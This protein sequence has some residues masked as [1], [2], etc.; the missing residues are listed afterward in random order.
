MTLAK[1]NIKTLLNAVKKNN[2]PLNI[3]IEVGG[4]NPKIDY[5]C[6]KCQGLISHNQYRKG[7]GLCKPCIAIN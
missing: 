2:R 3:G 4:K 5:Y 7:R 1:K 6:D